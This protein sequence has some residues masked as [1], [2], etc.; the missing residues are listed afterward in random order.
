M[1][2]N[3][4]V[5]PQDFTV[6]ELEADERTAL[7]MALALLEKTAPASWPWRSA[8]PKLL[9]LF[10]PFDVEVLIRTPSRKMPRE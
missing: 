1:P 10:D 4:R 2:R 6:R 7:R 3:N 5:D 8:L 9:A